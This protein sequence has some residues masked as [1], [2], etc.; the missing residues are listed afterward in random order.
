MESVRAAFEKFGVCLSLRK[1]VPR[2]TSPGGKL[3]RP[4]GAAHMAVVGV[5]DGAELLFR[6]VY[7]GVRGDAVGSPL[8]RSDQT[9]VTHSA[10]TPLTH[11][12]PVPGSV[13]PHPTHHPLLCNPSAS[14]GA[15]GSSHASCA[16]GDAA[17]LV[18]ASHTY[19]S[20]DY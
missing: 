8:A 5:G 10:V 17:R 7:P 6:G 20:L 16:G 3:P 4:R 15:R 2:F 11:H 18:V 19:I 14:E 12:S 1:L 9:A 13:K